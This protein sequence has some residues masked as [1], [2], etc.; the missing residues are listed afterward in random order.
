MSFSCQFFHNVNR[1]KSHP[2]HIFKSKQEPDPVLILQ[3]GKF[4]H[5]S[6]TVT[7]INYFNKQYYLLIANK[8]KKLHQK[9]L[10]YRLFERLIE[11]LR[12]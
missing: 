6:L 1:M 8:H 7:L 9:L 4:L 5:S 11:D 2:V 10:T 3:I 12:K